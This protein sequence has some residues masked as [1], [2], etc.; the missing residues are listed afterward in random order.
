M[1]AVFGF[2]LRFRLFDD[3]MF[4]VFGFFLRFRLFRFAFPV[5]R[6][7]LFVSRAVP[8]EPTFVPV[9]AFAVPFPPP[10]AVP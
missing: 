3:L 9:F 4:A 1:F 8:F 7:C 10:F 2:F 6:G 5:E